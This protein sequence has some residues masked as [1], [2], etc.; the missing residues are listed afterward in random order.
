M[1][2]PPRRLRLVPKVTFILSSIAIHYQVVKFVYNNHTP[3]DLLNP[4]LLFVLPCT[5]FII[6]HGLGVLRHHAPHP[7]CL[8]AE[9]ST[10]GH[11]DSSM[12]DNIGIQ[13]VPHRYTVVSRRPAVEE[14][15]QTDPAVSCARASARG[16]TGRSVVFK[17]RSSYGLPVVVDGE[18]HTTVDL[19]VDF[20]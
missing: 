5:I 12:A 19:G 10:M 17:A 6:S 7:N 4:S 1:D 14:D 8:V 2:P 16:A 9:V 20:A 18:N 13:A 11:C 15:K 3:H